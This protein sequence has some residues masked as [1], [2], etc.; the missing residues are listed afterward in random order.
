MENPV[1]E[2]EIATGKPCKFDKSVVICK[3]YK[4]E[5]GFDRLRHVFENHHI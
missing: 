5:D 4:A 1:K 3:Q 2:K